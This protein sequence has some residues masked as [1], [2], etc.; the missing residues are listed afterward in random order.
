MEKPRCTKCNAPFLDHHKVNTVQDKGGFYH[1]NCIPMNTPRTVEDWLR[2]FERTYEV[3]P[4]GNF[5]EQ[6]IPQNTNEEPL[7][8]K[9]WLERAL[10][11]IATSAREEETQR[12]GLT[13]AAYFKGLR[14]ISDPQATYKNLLKALFSAPPQ[15]END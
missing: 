7:P 8:I 1:T 4:T 3:K 6:L 5:S 13:L 14:I 12:I 9:G 2:E 15:K 11:D 10:T